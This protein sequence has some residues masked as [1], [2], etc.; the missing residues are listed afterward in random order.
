[1]FQWFLRTACRNYRKLTFSGMNTEH[2][3]IAELLK[4]QSRKRVKERNQQ[5]L[6][7]KK[8]GTL[9]TRNGS[10]PQPTLP[11]VNELLNT[12]DEKSY[13]QKYG[14]NGNYA[15]RTPPPPPATYNPY[16]NAYAPT[17]SREWNNSPSVP[18]GSPP[19][20][21]ATPG[22]STITSKRSMTTLV[23]AQ[24]TAGGRPLSPPPRPGKGNTSE[25]QQQQAYYDADNYYRQDDRYAYAQG[26]GYYQTSN[27]AY[28]NYNYDAHHYSPEQQYYANDSRSQH[29]YTQQGYATD[30]YQQQQQYADYDYGNQPRRDE[31]PESQR[32]P[33]DEYGHYGGFFTEEPARAPTPVSQQPAPVIYEELPAPVAYSLDQI[34][35]TARVEPQAPQRQFSL[36]PEPEARVR[37]APPRGASRPARDN[38]F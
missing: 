32:N 29:T 33:E 22:T 25:G 18:Q 38:M 15:Y 3:S 16:T 5:L 35:Y 1:M 30:R 17:P 20:R 37:E 6:K 31:Y 2:Y 10:V 21:S 11:D 12:S 26:N 9:P 14:D 13:S 23:A 4:K 34:T 27:D 7:A 19:T 24:E 36:T 8:N 28:Q